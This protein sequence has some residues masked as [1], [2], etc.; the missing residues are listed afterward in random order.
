[1]A[2]PVP[3]ARPAPPPT[4]GARPT[5]APAR[6]APPPAAKPK[7]RLGN[8]QRGILRVPL[9]H[10][11]YGPRGVGKTSLG[12]DAPNPI[13]LDIEGGSPLVN[14]A[15]YPFRD[16]VGGH[17]PRTYEE[18][19]AAIDDLLANPG[20]GYASLVLDTLDALE[21]LIHEFICRRDGKAN[22]ESYGYGKGYKVA[23]V[24]IRVLQERLDRLVNSGM[25]IIILAHSDEK[26]FKNPRGP[27]YDR[28]RS[29]MHELA[30]SKIAGWCDVVGFVDFESGG[31][32]LKGDESQAK[33]ARGWSTGRRLVQLVPDAAVPDAKCRLSLP[34]ELELDVAHPWAPFANAKL[35]AEDATIETLT[36]DILAEVDRITG[37][38]RTM[39][40]VTDAGRRA[41]PAEIQDVIA[42]G[43]ASVLARVLAGLKA[44]AAVTAQETP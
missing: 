43:D 36:V 35:K 19:L 4:N 26:T 16:E 32:A 14:V 31:A 25:A 6:P 20:H 29:E 40:F 22:V 27:D 2:T 17:V 5:P 18:V 13:F 9:R 38:D 24:E 37:G 12:A 8:V 3:T 10:L 34:A 41:T 33:R 15:R 42:K 39:E 44:T 7:S 21:S 30:W 11:F 23:V 28:Y 1:M